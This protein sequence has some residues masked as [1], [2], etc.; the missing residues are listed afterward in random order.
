MDQRARAGLRRNKIILRE[1]RPASRIPDING[2]II[3]LYIAGID[4]LFAHWKLNWT[5]TRETVRL[6]VKL[7]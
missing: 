3:P 4:A 1:T 2:D 5:V 6:P 7:T